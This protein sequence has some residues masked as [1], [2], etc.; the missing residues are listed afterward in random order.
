ML[1]ALWDLRQCK[2]INR[3]MVSKENV[4]RTLIFLFKFDFVREND[5]RTN[6]VP[7]SSQS[8][9]SLK[10]EKITEKYVLTW[11]LIQVLWFQ[12]SKNL[13]P[14]HEVRDRMHFDL[15]GLT[16]DNRQSFEKLFSMF[17]LFLK[18]IPM[19]NYAY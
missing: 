8:Y 13:P 10:M 1:T 19:T 7:C 3:T 6:F 11:E 17:F 14:G 2:S 15:F 4:A 18:Y 9:K 5:V 12:S 16:F